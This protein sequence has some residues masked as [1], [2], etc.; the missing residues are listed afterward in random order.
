MS[1]T[2]KPAR[3]T[4]ASI[5]RATGVSVQTVSNVVNGKDNKVAATTRSLVEA[6]IERQGY[7]PNRAAQLLRTHHSR[8]LGYRMHPVVGG[9]NGSVLDRLL[10]GLTERAHDRGYGIIVFSAANDEEEIKQYRALRSENNV[11]G[12]LLTSTNHG[13]QR[14]DWLTERDI[15]FVAFGRPW[16]RDDAATARTHLWVDVDGYSGVLDATRA[17]IARDCTRIGFLGWPEGSGAGDDRRAGW[18]TALTEAGCTE[19]IERR[20]ED[21]VSGAHTAAVELDAEGIDGLICA[22]DSLAIG[23]LVAL[24]A[25]NPQLAANI[26]GFDDTP[27]AEAVGL[28]SIN[29]PIEMA[30]ARMIDL[31]IDRIEATA[32]PA[33]KAERLLPPA[34]RYRTPLPGFTPT[35]LP[36][37][38]PGTQTAPPGAHTKE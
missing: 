12:F 26:V 15:P 24:R 27:V 16:G 35:N 19:R 17:L 4:L 21:S 8:L 32:A 6:E 18:D 34:V 29:Q 9:I 28:T 14:A 2:P 11:D 10:H 22:S 31:L 30:A 20:I 36:E 25:A 7:R 5:A 3:A 1:D 38:T 37:P 13:D 23:A 33:P